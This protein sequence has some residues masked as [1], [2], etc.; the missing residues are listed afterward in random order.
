MSASA[1]VNSQAKQGG[2]MATCTVTDPTGKSLAPVNVFVSPATWASIPSAEQVAYLEA[3]ALL[4]CGYPTDAN[5]LVQPYATGGAP[6]TPSGTDTR[7]WA[8]LWV[9]GTI[10]S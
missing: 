2:L 5:T 4:V 9:A 3:R 8:A 1:V 10:L 6:T 7:N